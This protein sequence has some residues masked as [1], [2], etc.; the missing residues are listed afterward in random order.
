[1]ICDKENIVHYLHGELTDIERKNMESHLQTC[2][3]C[4]QE[5]NAALKLWNMF[6]ELPVEPASA[7]ME[8]DFRRMLNGF[9][10]EES[11][12]NTG[13]WKRL[14]ALRIH[15]SY[16]VAMLVIGLLTGYLI[17]SAGN[18]KAMHDQFAALSDEVKGMRQT[19]VLS[20][21][22]NPAATERIKAVAY[23]EQVNS[24]DKKVMDALLTT[25]NNDPNINVRL[26]TLDALMA[27]AEDPY[28]REGL[29]RSITQQES[30][31]M[32]AALAD[33]M[34]KLKEQRALQ[35]WKKQLS[36]PELDQSVREKIRTSM[37]AIQQTSI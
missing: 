36:E 2:P 32:Q 30:P 4:R 6:E 33:A 22:Q 13:F 10:Y 21:L 15:W 1:M 31:L 29:V 19:V 9:K 11:R 35:I 25:L 16:G 37:Q 14:S 23:T 5:L 27:F 24:S 18:N 8:A 34:V 28:V 12:R 3:S 26:V 20:L 17:Q 7:N